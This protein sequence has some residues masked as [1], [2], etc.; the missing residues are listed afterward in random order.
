V[1][2]AL[3]DMPDRPK[4]LIRDMDSKFSAEFDAILVSEGIKVLK[5]GPKKPN[6]N[7]FAER[8]IQTCRQE[9][10]DSFMIFGEGHLRYLLNQY[11]RFYN[12][13]RPHQSLISSHRIRV[14]RARHSVNIQ[15]TCWLSPKF[16]S[17]AR[18][19]L[20]PKCCSDR[21]LVGSIDFVQDGRRQAL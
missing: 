12:E 14:R 10:L 11:V 15:I 17:S 7:A 21:I 5:V 1:S 6:L 19:R 2:I 20:P 16:G 18:R 3:A 4:Y 8:W 13:F 9:C